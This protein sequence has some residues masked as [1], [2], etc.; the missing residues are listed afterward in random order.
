MLRQHYGDDL[1]TPKDK[2]VFDDWNK[3]RVPILAAHPKSIG[4][5]LNLQHGGHTCVW[6]S[7]TWDLEL[8]EQGNSRLPRQGQKNQVVV[9][10]LSSPG[11]VD[12]KVYA[13][14]RRK[15]SVQD[16]LIEYLHSP[17]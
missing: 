14:L 10:M 9:H 15:A 3:G 1:R 6:M 13:A 5:G 8:W 17:V 7:P 12:A 2:N 16:A 11:T 4:H